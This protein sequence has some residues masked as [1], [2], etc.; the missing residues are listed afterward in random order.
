MNS[1][2]S[3]FVVVFVSDLFIPHHSGFFFSH[4]GWLLCKKHPDVREKGKGVDVSDL[5][6]DPV[7]K[8]QSKYVEHN[9]KSLCLINYTKYVAP[10]AGTT[11][12]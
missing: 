9:G 1:V 6:S 4:I 7:L 10:L 11:S 5:R 3:V 8:F 12:T 2:L